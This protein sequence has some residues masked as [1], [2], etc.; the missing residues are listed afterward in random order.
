[1]A[2][3]MKNWTGLFKAGLRYPRISV[4][5]D[6]RSKLHKRK[7]SPILFVYNLMFECPSKNKENCARKAFEQKDRETWIEV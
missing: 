4:K 2:V 7:L 5:S 3:N 6:L 1:M